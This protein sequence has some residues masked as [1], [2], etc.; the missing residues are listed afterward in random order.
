MTISQDLVTFFISTSYAAKDIA[1]RVSN[2]IHFGI[3]P[4]NQANN[5]PRMFLSRSSKDT[6]PNMDGTGKTD[7]CDEGFDL[8]VISNASSDILVITD[9]LWENV[10]CHFG[11]ITST[12]LV[13][14]MFLSNQDDEYIVKGIGNDIGLDI[15]AFNLRVVHSTTT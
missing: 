2:R 10:N 14:G 11:F 4:K 13:K 9:L 8:E 6:K 1:S 15:A 3:V 5:F 12:K 7:Y